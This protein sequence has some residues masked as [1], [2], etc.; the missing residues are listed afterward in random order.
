MGLLFFSLKNRQ[1]KDCVEL[2]LL[3]TGHAFNAFG[4]INLGDLFFLPLNSFGG[5]PAS[6]C[7]TFGAHFRIDFKF[8]QT[9]APFGRATLL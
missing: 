4:L 5:T 9:D 6:A 7:A 3:E 1:L 8:Q 2:T